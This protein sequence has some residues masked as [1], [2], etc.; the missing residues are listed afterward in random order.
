MVKAVILAAGLGTRLVPYSKEMPKEM[1]PIFVREEGSLVLKPVLQVVFEQLYEAGIREFCFV[2]GRGKRSV[3]DHFTP[4]WDYVEYLREK[5]KY[6]QAA[7]LDRFY[8]MIESSNITWVNQPSPKGTGDAVLRAEHFVEGEYFVA[9]AGDNVFIGEN[10]AAKLLEVYSK[11][12]API[13]T[14]KK[15]KDPT[16]YGVVIGD[17]VS[18]QGVDAPLY[19]VKWIKEKCKEPPSNLANVSLYVFP[20]EIFD[21]IRH[22]KPSPRGEIEVTSSIEELIKEGV[23][24]YAFES[25]AFWVDVGTPETYL[26]ALLYS[27]KLSCPSRDIG[28]VVERLLGLVV[29]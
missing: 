22:T 25:D 26:E 27:L 3:E 13:I 4:D 6:L 20:P 23:E 19:R 14:V 9:T 8:R 29:G 21:A 16:R 17:R 18:M 7:M 12:K 24:F 28:A 15:V 5:R 10:V 11:V 2:V 1:L